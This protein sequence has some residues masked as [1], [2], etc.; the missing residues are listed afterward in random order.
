MR[1]SFFLFISFLNILT[2]DASDKC[3]VSNGNSTFDC[4]PTFQI[5]TKAP[6]F[7]KIYWQI[8]SSAEFDWVS[9]ELEDVT[10]ASNEIT[11]SE[12]T[13]HLLTPGETYYFRF[14]TQFYNKS[15]EWSKPFDFSIGTPKENSKEYSWQKSSSIDVATWHNLQP[16]LLP[17]NHY[18]KP[19]LDQIFS[20][21]RA[22][23]NKQAMKKAGFEGLE[24]WRWNKIFVARHPNLKGF[25]I[26]AYLDDHC[27]M[28]DKILVNR[29]IGAEAIRYVIAALGLQSYFKVPHKWLYPLPDSPPSLPGL[30]GKNFILIV[31]DMNIVDKAKNKK[32]YRESI[33]ENQLFAL[34]HVMNSV[35]LADSVHIYN[36][37]FCKDGKIAFIDTEM[38]HLWPIAFHLLTP[39]LSLK[40]QE[41]WKKLTS[42]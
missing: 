7:E 1:L 33:T 27:F 23:A 3:W 20:K 15:T 22:S 6:T 18:L 21:A 26:K 13:C 25:L 2:L 9:P 36:I 35:G 28:D 34:F 12:E 8:S 31:E 39:S 24:E 4:V 38:H 16:Y 30:K 42:E 29:I 19:K 10:H 14:K 11:L 40:M 32:K 41:C 17:S 5:Q 37:P